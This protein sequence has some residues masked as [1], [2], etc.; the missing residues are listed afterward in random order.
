MKVKTDLKAGVNLGAL[1]GPS[2][3]NG[4]SHYNPNGPGGVDGLTSTWW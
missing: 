3:H 4:G 2:R 1:L